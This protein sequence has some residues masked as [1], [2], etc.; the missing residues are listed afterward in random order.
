MV[1]MIVGYKSVTRKL[2]MTNYMSYMKMEK[3]TASF[4]AIQGKMP[5]MLQITE[6]GLFYVVF[7]PLNSITDTPTSFRHGIGFSS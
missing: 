5:M 4:F 1:V 2:H 7:S 6:D 3:K